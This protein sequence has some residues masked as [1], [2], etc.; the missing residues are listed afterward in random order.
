M[1]KYHSRISSSSS[2][3]SSPSSSLYVWYAINDAVFR[4]SISSHHTSQPE[5]IH[6]IAEQSIAEQVDG[7]CHALTISCEAGRSGWAA[8]STYHC[9]S[10]LHHSTGHQLRASLQLQAKNTIVNLLTGAG[11]G[12]GMHFIS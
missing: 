9:C 6:A 5:Q 3:S 1:T 4:S 10:H 2:A 12:I 7:H 11:A 8:C